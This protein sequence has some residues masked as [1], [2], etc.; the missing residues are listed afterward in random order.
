MGSRIVYLYAAGGRTPRRDEPITSENCQAI[1]HKAR[2]CARVP[3]SF[4]LLCCLTAAQ[5]TL[6]Q[7]NIPGPGIISTA[8]DNGTSS[9]SGD[10]GLEAAAQSDEPGAGDDTFWD[11]DD[12][13]LY[14][15]WQNP[16][17]SNAN[18]FG[19]LCAGGNGTP[20]STSQTNGIGSPSLDGKS[21]KI[22]LTY[23]SGSQ[24][25][26]TVTT[27]GNTVTWASGT[28]FYRRWMYWRQ[29]RYSVHEDQQFGLTA[30]S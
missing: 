30:R 16:P 21:M 23:P 14:G 4:A 11:L 2:H 15:G 20:S 13:E 24:G 17:C 6:G 29:K 27:S 19:S 18:P 8:A 9:Y 1:K 7:V 22:S 26:G 3:L 25:S 5:S 28:K 12:V 10:G